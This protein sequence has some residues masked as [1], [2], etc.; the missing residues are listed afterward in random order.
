MTKTEREQAERQKREFLDGTKNMR[1]S[2][3]CERWHIQNCHICD[4]LVCGDNTTP[5]AM[6]FREQRKRDQNDRGN[7]E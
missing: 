7:R 2:V 5:E 4:R 6:A 1:P 3:I